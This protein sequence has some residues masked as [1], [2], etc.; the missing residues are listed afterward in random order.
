MLVKLNCCVFLNKQHSRTIDAVSP[1]HYEPLEW[2]IA[3]CRYMI[4][5]YVTVHGEVISHV[6]I[7]RSLVEDGGLYTCTASNRAG[8]AAHSARLNVY[9]EILLWNHHEY[10]NCVKSNKELH[11]K[12]QWNHSIGPPLVHPIPEIKA[13]VGK[14]VH[15]ICPASGY[16]LEK[17]VWAKG[18][19]KQQFNKFLEKA[20]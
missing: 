17:I 11:L 1:K 12:W 15:I 20:I 7:S 6:N 9:G 18:G 14:A 16:P 4:G 2:S 8:S 13:V 3:S 19:Q 10:S 5:Q